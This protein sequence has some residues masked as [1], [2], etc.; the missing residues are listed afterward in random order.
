MIIDKPPL[1]DETTPADAPPAY[2]SLDKK[3]RGSFTYPPDK[4]PTAGPSSHP[5]SLQPGGGSSSGSSSRLRKPPPQGL[6]GPVSPKGKSKWLFPF[7]GQ[8]RAAQEARITVQN[9]V[10]DVVKAPDLAGLSVLHDCAVA[11]ESHDLVFGDI[12]QDRY[13]EGHCALYWAIVKRPR[14]GGKSGKG[15]KDY[16]DED[17][18]CGDLVEAM[19]AMAAPLTDQTVSEIRLA[20]LLGSDQALFQRLR[21][22]PAFAPLSGTDEILLGG[23]IPQDDVSVHEGTGDAGEF[24]AVFRLVQFQKRMRISKQ[25]AVEFIARGMFS[26]TSDVLQQDSYLCRANVVLQVHP[27]RWVFPYAPL[28]EGRVASLAYLDGA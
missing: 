6:K 18:T 23:S 3:P 27:I 16:D 10:R 9:L 11:C 25:V 12:L 15:E 5:P 19:L 8:S 7:A 4:E 14:E 1:P 2:E 24:V 17:H 26:F 22:T 20:C 28:R 21:Y 13:I